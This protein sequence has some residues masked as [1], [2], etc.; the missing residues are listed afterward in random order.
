M[1]NL[2]REIERYKQFRAV[3]ALRLTETTPLNVELV[4]IYTDE[5]KHLD[6]IIARLEVLA[7]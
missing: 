1:I 4:D 5:I 3:T 2:R 7:K 6:L